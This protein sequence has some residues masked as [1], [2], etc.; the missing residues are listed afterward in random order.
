MRSL[1]SSVHVAGAPDQAAKAYPKRTSLSRW[2]CR[3][4]L[5]VGSVTKG[6]TMPHSYFDTHDGETFISDEVGLEL[7]GVEAAHVALCNVMS[8]V[9]PVSD[10]RAVFV[11]R[12]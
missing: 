2:H 1:N 8:D 5:S 12:S 3:P 11:R 10:Q 6:N 9:V 7:D 4:G